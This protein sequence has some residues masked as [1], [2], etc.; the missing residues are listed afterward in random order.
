MSIYV[1]AQLYVPSWPVPLST[2]WADEDD[3]INIL[4]PLKG[5]MKSEVIAAFVT[6]VKFLLYLF[7]YYFYHFAFYFRFFLISI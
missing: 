4:D 5:Y 3:F 2:L 7:F 1:S 6:D